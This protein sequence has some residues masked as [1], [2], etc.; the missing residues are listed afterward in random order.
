MSYLYPGITKLKSMFSLTINSNLDL[1]TND[2]AFENYQFEEVNENDELEARQKI[3][4]NTPTNT[5]R[6]LNSIKSN[7]HKALEKYYK[8]IKKEAFI[9]ILLDLRKKKLLLPIITKRN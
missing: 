3:K 7:L 9:V 8:V 4:I 5:F 6:L 1:E 2:D